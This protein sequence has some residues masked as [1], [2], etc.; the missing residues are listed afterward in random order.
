[1][2]IISTLLTL[3]T[4]GAWEN[5]NH[6]RGVAAREAAAERW[7][8][9][10][11]CAPI[12]FANEFRERYYHGDR[13]EVVKEIAERHLD[14]PRWRRTYDQ[15][16]RREGDLEWPAGRH[17]TYFRQHYADHGYTYYTYSEMASLGYHIAVDEA[18]KEGS[19]DFVDRLVDAIFK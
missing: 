19:K 11:N 8:R 2:G 1:M 18:Y 16:V 3:V 12:E 6:K 15:C 9:E 17:D 7:K 4:L 13:Y 14:D 5:H 10:H